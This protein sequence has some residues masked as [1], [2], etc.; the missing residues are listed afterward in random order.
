MSVQNGLQASC[1]PLQE[2]II[3]Q[4]S[5]FKT[6]QH[7]QKCKFVILVHM[8]SRKNYGNYTCLVCY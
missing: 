2:S 4:Q 1:Y 6:L 7:V 3:L 8:F 5:K